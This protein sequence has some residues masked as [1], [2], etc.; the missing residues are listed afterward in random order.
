M[1]PIYTDAPCGLQYYFIFFMGSGCCELQ[2]PTGLNYK[3][4]LPVWLSYFIHFLWFH[5]SSCQVP[6]L[7]MVLLFVCLL[8]FISACLH[9]LASIT[10]AGFRLVGCSPWLTV[11]L[12]IL[13][14]PISNQ[15]LTYFSCPSP[16]PAPFCTAKHSHLSIIYLSLLLKFRAGIWCSLRSSTPVRSWLPTFQLCSGT[17][18]E[19]FH[20]LN[21]PGALLTPGPPASSP[22]LLTLSYL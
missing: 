5:F 10:E 1:W 16:T 11:R 17:P 2:I 7:L 22:Q 21:F 6:G 12:K 20:E 18:S 15:L 9:L 14:H 13:Q 3:S 4:S 8:K 19:H